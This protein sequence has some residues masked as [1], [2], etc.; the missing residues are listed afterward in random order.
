MPDKLGIL[1]HVTTGAG[2]DFPQFPTVQIHSIARDRQVNHNS[3]LNQSLHASCTRDYATR[4]RHSNITILKFVELI[5]LDR[6]NGI[7]HKGI[8]SDLCSEEDWIGLKLSY[9]R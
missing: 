5:T 9:L 2:R 8:S 1:G 3:H 4:M 7:A 6:N